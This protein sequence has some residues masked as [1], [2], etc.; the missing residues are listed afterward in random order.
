[1]H[2]EMIKNPWMICTKLPL[3]KEIKKEFRQRRV[4]EQL[5]IRRAMM[6][7]VDMGDE[8][9]LASSER[10]RKAKSISRHFVNIHPDPSYV[11]LERERECGVAEGTSKLVRAV[12]GAR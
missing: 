11:T 1:M 2:K 12:F 5:E 8:D 3:E 6:E 10:H 9:P 7:C 4:R